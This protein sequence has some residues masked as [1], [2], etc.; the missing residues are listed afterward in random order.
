V[1]H[2]I[3]LILD[4]ANERAKYSANWWNTAKLPRAYI[5]NKQQGSYWK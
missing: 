4:Q 1:K 3:V 2:A 5:N